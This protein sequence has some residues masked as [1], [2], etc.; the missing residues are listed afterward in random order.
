M[1]PIPRITKIDRRRSI[2]IDDSPCF[3]TGNGNGFIRI[4]YDDLFAER[5]DKMFQ[6]PADLDPEGS[7]EVN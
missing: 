2:I 5:I 1:R 7:R 3:L 6:P 4:I